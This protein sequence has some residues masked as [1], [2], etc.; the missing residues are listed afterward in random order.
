MWRWHSY[1]TST[2]SSQGS[3]EAAA[4]WDE[5]R[6]EVSEHV[7]AAPLRARENALET[8]RAPAV[9]VKTAGSSLGTGAAPAYEGG[10]WAPCLRAEGCGLQT[11]Q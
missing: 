11:Q 3:E 9:A 4:A 8:R 5:L 6:G 1:R 7:L 10:L 2:P